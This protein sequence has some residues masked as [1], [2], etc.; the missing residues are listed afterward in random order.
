MST[1]VIM[2]TLGLT[3]EEGTIVKWLKR[4]G[5][6]VNKDEPLFEVETDKAVNEVPAPT[7]GV[8]QR[9]IAAEGTTVPVRQA[10]AVIAEPGEP[11]PA[12]APA[13]GPVEAAPSPAPARPEP[14]PAAAPPQ[15]AQRGPTAGPRRV[16][17]RARR[18]AR[19]LGVEVGGLVGSGPEGRVV[20]RDVR[21]AAQ[22]RPAA[23]PAGRVLASPLARKLAAEHQIDLAGL[24][25]SGPGGRIVEKDVLA[26]VEASRAAAAPAPSPAAPTPTPAEPRPAAAGPVP[27]G[28]LRRITAE[29]MAASS[30]VVARV[31]LFM[32]VDM[33]EAVRFRTQLAPEFER[34]YGA[35]LGY[36][37]MIAKACGL[38]LRDHPELNAQWADGAVQPLEEVNVGVAVAL[39]EGLLVVVLRNADARPLHQ[40]QSDLNGLVE[41][42]RAGRLS[43]DDISGS[44]FTITNLG[45]YGVEGFT[46]IVNLPE[47]AILG[48]GKIA[49][50]PA[51]VDD[52]LAIREQMTLS[53]AFDHRVTDGA[54]AGRLLQRVKEVLEAPY[55]LLT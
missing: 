50:Q 51:V 53:L 19:E 30:K 15:L 34:R 35:R 16:S 52:Q 40:L 54:P 14:G 5:E 43:P 27:L 47:A 42:A 29:R 36:D 12:P 22:A 3:M 44:T 39:D 9:I 26:A 2:P 37:T 1:E 49:R 7:S 10:I 24:V 18:L 31:T 23:A 11:G 28:R 8:L 33:A 21:A 20:E 6:T 38:A 45:A 46:P 41:R 4:E 25:G 55:V 17:P 32:T 13:A 48:V